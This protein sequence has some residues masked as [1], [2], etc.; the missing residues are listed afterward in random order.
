[1]SE[2]IPWAEAS[3]ALSHGIAS[4][5]HGL[6]ATID[7]ASPQPYP[8]TKYIFARGTSRMLRALLA[9]ALLTSTVF[10]Q[11]APRDHRLDKPRDYNG[12]FPWTP[13]RDLK[14]WNER[15]EVVRRQVLVS[16][17]LWPM[18]PRSP[19][20]PVIHG[21]IERDGST[22]EKVFFASLPGHYVSG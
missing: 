10:A 2:A 19:L 21:K 22:I 6:E 15:R 14:E 12:Y 18:P 9:L 5:I 20:Q 1:M 3:E 11:D 16:Q 7:A 4:L 8:W 13:P 17:G